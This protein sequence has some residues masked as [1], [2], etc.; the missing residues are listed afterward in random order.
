MESRLL[1]QVL[2]KTFKLTLASTMRAAPQDR[3]GSLTYPCKTSARMSGTPSVSEIKSKL[4]S[5]N[6]GKGI[7]VVDLNVQVT[8][9]KL[10]IGEGAFYVSIF[11]AFEADE[12]IFLYNIAYS[13][14]GRALHI[15]PSV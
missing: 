8:K 1:L 5:A 7:S 14:E 13:T 12:N 4:S 15:I 10:A 3:A 2:L 11:I 6:Y 9:L